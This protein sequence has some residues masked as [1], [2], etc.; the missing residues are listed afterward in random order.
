MPTEVARR[1]QLGISHYNVRATIKMYVARM[2]RR[3]MQAL[4][5][6]SHHA[7]LESCSGTIARATVRKI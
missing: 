4:K 3:T 6:E 1:L 2:K 5:E 7:P